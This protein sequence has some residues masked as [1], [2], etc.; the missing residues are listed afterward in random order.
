MTTSPRIPWWMACAM[1]GA[2]GLMLA[3]WLAPRQDL[4]VIPRPAADRDVLRIAYAQM[5]VVDPHRWY[6]PT[7]AQNQ[8]ILGLWEPLI[9]CDPESGQPMPAAAES[10]HWSEDRLTLTVKL[11]ATGR[12]SNGDPVTAGDFVRSWR[13]LVGHDMAGAIVLYPVQGAEAVNRGTAAPDT[14]G[15]EAVDALTLR[16]RLA[17]VRSTFV[18]ELADPMLVPLH[19]TTPAVLAEDR[20]WRE[21]AAL[22]TNG[23]FRLI[24]A[25]KDGFRLGVSRHYRNHPAVRLAGVEFIRADTASMARLLV[26]VG[27]ADLTHLSPGVPPEGWPTGRAVTEATELSL[28]ISSLDLNVTRGPLR[29][30]RVRR[31][32]A[33]AVDRSEPITGEDAGRFVPAYSWVP[34]MPGR[35]GM[36]LFRED[37]AEA[38][39]LLAEAGYPGGRDFPVLIL[40]VNPRRDNYPFLQAW[41]DRWFRELGVRTYLA[42]EPSDKRTSRVRSGNFDVAFNG[43][44]ATVPDAGDLL[45]IFA[46]PERFNAPHWMNPVNTQLMAEANRKAGAERL[47]LL[48]AFER[49]VMAE[50]PTIPMLFERRRTLLAGEVEGWYADPLGRQALKR[51]AL[52]PLVPPTLGGEEGL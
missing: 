45:G 35:A 37:A 3:V 51:L 52:A 38:R 16:I 19:V 44:I 30:V 36:A 5:V 39:R 25:S 6:F 1:A 33:L 2:G 8:L 4:P 31:A 48:E 7:P 15:V 9:E 29:D 28:L 13:R 42:Y 17:A 49:H 46:H 34:D 26:A 20:S 18:A 14:L 21:P 11:R 32:L 22:V 27:R 10:W 24:R 40:P 47:E 12:W 41:T 50:V 43:V 23:A